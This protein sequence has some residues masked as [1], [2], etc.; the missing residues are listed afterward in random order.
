[1]PTDRGENMRIKIE[2]H[3]LGWVYA[4]NIP[5][6]VNQKHALLYGV[7]PGIEAALSAM[8]NQI[9]GAP[10]E[11]D[12]SW[13]PTMEDPYGIAQ[14]RNQTTTPK[15]IISAESYETIKRQYQRAIALGFSIKEEK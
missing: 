7:V 5:L 14:T 10:L 13:K 1:M 9:I 11:L 8:V 6:D 15:N 2:S 12:V 4:N 3:L